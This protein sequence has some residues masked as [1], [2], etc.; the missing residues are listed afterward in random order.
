MLRLVAPLLLL[1][2]AASASAQVTATLDSS[3]ASYAATEPVSLTLTLT[4]T[5]GQPVT[6]SGVGWGNFKAKVS[7]D[8]AQVRADRVGFSPSWPVKDVQDA[9]RLTL[10]A[11]EST[12]FELSDT[13]NSL[14]VLLVPPR[15]KRGNK[16]KVKSYPLAAPGLYS[17][18]VRYRYRD[19]RFPGT[20]QGLAKSNSVQFVRTP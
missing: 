2:A 16:Y 14:D 12:A 7:L 4:N 19:R 3:S 6:V 13:G 11:G 15:E 17:V 18:E 10:Q 9:H 5:S 20:F 8:G 1:L